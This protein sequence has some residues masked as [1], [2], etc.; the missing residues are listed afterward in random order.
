MIRRFL[1]VSCIVLF[2]GCAV[3]PPARTTKAIDPVNNSVHFVVPVSDQDKSTAIITKNILFPNKRLTAG[4][5]DI[6]HVDVMRWQITKSGFSVERYMGIAGGGDSIFE[7]VKYE[8]TI[9]SGFDGGTKKLTFSPQTMNTLSKPNM[10]SGKK[11]YSL[12]FSPTQMVSAAK[13]SEY[14]WQFEVNSEFN[15]E[16]TYANFAR[17]ARKEV[18]S[19]S[20][21]KDSVSGKIFKVRYWV[22]VADQ[23]MPINVETYP[24]RNG[25]KVVVYANLRGDALGNTV[26]FSKTA[27]MLKAEVERIVKS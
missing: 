2:A 17:L 5:G 16:S 10:F 7:S 11:M 8:G 14:F 6:V 20:G 12:E 27:D 4:G 18:T 22:R 9:T 13:K 25:S 21:E 15:S 1:T 26:D 19:I 24:Y 3:Q 23:E